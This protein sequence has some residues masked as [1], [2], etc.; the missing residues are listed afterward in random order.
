MQVHKNIISLEIVYEDE[1]FIAINKPPGLLV[2]PDH[3]NKLEESILDR[4]KKKYND[5]YSVHRLDRETSGILIYAKNAL[6]HQKLSTQFEKHKIKKTYV[7]LVKGIMTNSEGI[8]DLPLSKKN[9]HANEM[10]VDKLYGK[11]SITEYKTIKRFE[12]F[13]LVEVFPHTGRTHQIRIHFK[14]IGH[15]LAIDK[16]YS[17]TD[18]I[19]L[20][21]IKPKFKQSKDIEKPLMDRLTLHALSL[22]FVHPVSFTKMKLEAPLWKDFKVLIKNLEKYS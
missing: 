11:P 4:L 9:K 22:E 18:G 10:V 1:H 12:K 7:A 20:S 2:I 21:D 6:V 17:N 3:F 5:I 16:L 19:F 15:P 13:T 14:A 8:I